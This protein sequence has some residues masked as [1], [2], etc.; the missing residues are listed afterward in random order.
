MSDVKIANIK[1]EWLKLSRAMDNLGKEFRITSC[2]YR[3]TREFKSD[4]GSLNMTVCSHPRHPYGKNQ[5]SSKC[6]IELC[7][8]F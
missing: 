7:P 8:M 3:N 6:I 1:A 4:E 5:F 2:D